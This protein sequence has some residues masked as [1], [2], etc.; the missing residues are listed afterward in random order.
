[1]R[2]IL[3]D[4]AVFIIILKCGALY[5]LSEQLEATHKLCDYV[6]KSVSPKIN[7]ASPVQILEFG[8]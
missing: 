7:L 5:D 1:M 4:F 2:N 6:K 3:C 8:A